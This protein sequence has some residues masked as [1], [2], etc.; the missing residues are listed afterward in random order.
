MA[1]N[2]CDLKEMRKTAMAKA[3]AK[4]QEL[5]DA[6]IPVS[7]EFFGRLIKQG[8]SDAR[9]ECVPISEFKASEEQLSLI[10]RVCPDHACAD[11]FTKAEVAETGE[12][13]AEAE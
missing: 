9:V 7:A 5:R 11:L 4:A 6:G 3:N 8:Y 2:T 10:E 1:D 13:A 12:E